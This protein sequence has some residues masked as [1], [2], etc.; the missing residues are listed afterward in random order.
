[1][2]RKSIYKIPQGKLVKIQL[3]EKNNKIKKIKITG[4]FFM[5]PE[6]II[7]KLERTLID[8]SLNKDSLSKKIDSFWKKNK[9][10]CFGIN[11]QGLTEAVL[12]AK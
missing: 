2:L 5:H 10:D 6:E 12:L 4:D 9:V 3:E 7:D 11:T 1:M 8:C